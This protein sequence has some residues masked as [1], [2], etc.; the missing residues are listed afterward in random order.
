MSSQDIER[1]FYLKKLFDKQ[2]DKADPEL[3]YHER[4]EAAMK[5]MDKK[6]GKDW[7]EEMQID[8]DKKMDSESAQPFYLKVRMEGDKEGLGYKGSEAPEE[9][10]RTGKSLKDKIMCRLGKM[11]DEVL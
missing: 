3:D 11:L 7:R 8:S 1:S 10:E 6:L 4:V 9:D 5:S 2:L